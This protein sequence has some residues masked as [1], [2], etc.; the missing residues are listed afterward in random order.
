MIFFTEGKMFSKAVEQNKRFICERLDGLD[1][2]YLDNLI[3]CES[4][5]QI[6]RN[7]IIAERDIWVFKE[8]LKLSSNPFF[9][10]SDKNTLCFEFES[11]LK[12]I[13]I[14]PF[15]DIG[16]FI[17][18]LVKL[19]LN[20]LSRPRTTLKYFIFKESLTVSIDEFLKYFAYFQDYEYLYQ[21]FY[22]FIANEVSNGKSHISIYEFDNLIDKFDKNQLFELDAQSFAS[23][24]QPIFDFFN[25]GNDGS[26]NLK[27]P[28]EAFILFFDDKKLRYVAGKLEKSFKGREI[29]QE[30]L[31]NVLSESL[32]PSGDI[33]EFPIDAA[34][35]NIYDKQIELT[36]EPSPE[37]SADDFEANIETI[38]DDAEIVE[39]DFAAE[40][41]TSVFDSIEELADVAEASEIDELL[42]ELD[43]DD[44]IDENSILNEMASE[45]ESIIENIEDLLSE[46]ALTET[47]EDELLSEIEGLEDVDDKISDTQDEIT[48]E[49][50]VLNIEDF[51][52][53]DFEEASEIEEQPQIEVA[54]EDVSDFIT[55]EVESIQPQKDEIDCDEQLEI[56]SRIAD[57]FIALLDL[58]PSETKFEL[59]SGLTLSKDTPD[60]D[61][62]GDVFSNIINFV[63]K[64]LETGSSP[65]EAEGNFEVEA[66]SE[67]TPDD[68]VDVNTFDFADELD[69]AQD[70]IL[71]DASIDEIEAVELGANVALEEEEDEAA[72]LDNF[73][74]TAEEE[75][76]SGERVTFKSILG[77]QYDESLEDYDID[78][79]GDFTIGVSPQSDEDAIASIENFSES[80]ENAN[81]EIKDFNLNTIAA[82][83]E[84]EKGINI[85][86]DKV[87][88]DLYLLNLN[89]EENEIR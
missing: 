82:I 58:D 29:S 22:D 25:V 8:K 30:Q 18:S 15:G 48:E 7:M 73:M 34:L 2:P 68:I 43:V 40:A 77:G 81:E 89:T 61:S 41:E 31:L 1:F 85:T 37:L 60:F 55:D 10:F 35:P 70:E 12:K 67:D 24:V 4:I 33:S 54:T 52:L 56:E 13:A 87:D 26:D 47:I 69:E 32:S 46:E 21:C 49:L 5:S 28:A 19:R 80:T 75:D 59:P 53:T 44:I 71:A 23:L 3:E 50:E 78:D 57:D 83:K 76:D 45:D 66:I 88:K 74:K 11:L 86:D 38:E 42:E 27:A 84:Y 51:D 64:V 36:D 79:F 14:V 6:Y 20:F 16:S 63:D 9:R 72:M 39:I 65:A 17:E 62:E